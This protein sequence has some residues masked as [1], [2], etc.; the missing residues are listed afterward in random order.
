MDIFNR[1]SPL[2]LE[3][4]TESFA[5]MLARQNLAVLK[6]WTDAEWALAPQ[7][8]FV[9]GVGPLLYVLFR[10]LPRSASAPLEFRDALEHQY[11]K[12]GQRVMR[13][14]E[15]FGQ[16]VHALA[17]VRVSLIPLKGIELG[18]AYYTDSATRPLADLDVLI[19]PND[20]AAVRERLTSL[21]YVVENESDKP[22]FVRP[23]NRHPV[24]FDSEHPDNPRRVEVHFSLRDEYRGGIVD[25]TE[26]AWET[27][28]APPGDI[29]TRQLDISVLWK[30]LLSHTSRDILS[31]RVRLI[32][33]QDLALVARVI[34]AR[35]CW[36]STRGPTDARVARFLYPALALVERY[37]GKL[38]PPEYVRAVAAHTPKRLRAWCERQTLFDVSWLSGKHIGA[39]QAV[40]L[41]ALTPYDA[42]GMGRVMWQRRELRLRHLFPN[43]A[44]SR[45]FFLAYP[46]YLLDQVRGQ[47]R[48]RLRRGRWDFSG[49]DNQ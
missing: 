35:G 48:Q 18:R 34:T 16:I 4:V 24:S 27:A 5:W 47:P 30:H 37:W 25:W 40:W 43:L 1:Y 36:S 32:Q 2:A 46:A 23:D 22:N 38:V 15:E 12:N 11:L 29:T 3:R 31:C 19:K 39:L 26:E 41:W 13:F 8:A 33:L 9:L 6:D 7:T 49:S 42:L 21:G 17:R 14:E 45:W 20:F 28:H 10:N 44:R